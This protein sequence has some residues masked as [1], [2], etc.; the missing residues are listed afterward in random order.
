MTK[1]SIV[2]CLVALIL[3][4]LRIAGFGQ[5]PNLVDQSFKDVAHLF[6]GGIYVA[7]RCTGGWFFA[8]WNSDSGDSH[9]CY[10]W[11]CFFGGSPWRSNVHPKAFWNT[12]NPILF[13]VFVMLCVVEVA[14]AVTM[15]G[16][17]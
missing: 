16:H 13:Y 12:G 3:A 9:W 14:C 5:T 10:W 7:W 1:S 17:S 8:V 4:G 2:I 6:V 11:D 15:R